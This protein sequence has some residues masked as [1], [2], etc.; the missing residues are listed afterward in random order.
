MYTYIAVLGALA[1]EKD[2][3]RRRCWCTYITLFM[4]VYVFIYTYMSVYISMYICLSLHLSPS[5]FLSLPLP[6]SL[7]LSHTHT[8]VRRQDQIG[9][10]QELVRHLRGEA[11]TAEEL[12]HVTSIEANP[13]PHTPNPA[14][15]GG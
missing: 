2:V 1:A 8:L 7:A 12:R 11:M 15:S 6:L 3:Q 14:T 10:L 9:H 5:L 4:F 13:K